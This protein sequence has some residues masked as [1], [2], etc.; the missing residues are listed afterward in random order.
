M[1]SASVS[2]GYSSFQMD[3]LVRIKNEVPALEVICG[4]IVTSKQAKSLAHAGADGL[5]VGM[6]SGSICTTQEV[7]LPTYS[8][9]L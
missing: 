9:G 4:N 3:M 8:P 2:A 7:C 1:D 6:G 5:R